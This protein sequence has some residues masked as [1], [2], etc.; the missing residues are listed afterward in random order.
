MEPT[1]TGK[2]VR[3][4]LRPLSFTQV[5][6]V[7]P[8]R[9]GAADDRIDRIY[10]EMERV[11]GVISPPVALHSPAPD[12]LA[13]SWV[14]LYETLLVPGRV[15]RAA[16]EAVATAVSVRNE[17]PYCVTVHSTMMQSLDH[18]KEAAAIAAD[19]TEEISDPEVREISAWALANALPETAAGH[20]APFPAGQAPEI[21]GT[22]LAFHYFNRVVNV[23]LPDAP[24]PPN[25]PAAMLTVVL[26]VLSRLMRSASGQT[27]P[28]GGS[29]GL[30]PNAPL[31]QNLW[32]AAGNPDV[33]QG[34]AR[35]SGAVEA[36]GLRS[37]P[38]GVREL[39]SAE[40]AAWDGQPKGPS[41][42][43][44]EKAISALPAEEQP[45][46][47]L[48]LLVALA[49]YQVDETAIDAFQAVQPTDAALVEFV[50]WAAFTASAHATTWM[51]IPGGAQ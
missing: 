50:S 19:R 8:D 33:A 45:A 16:K 20:P 23:F 28:A 10:Q 27:A 21:V 13:A 3:A 7:V 41:R 48:A 25:V 9:K 47:R 46:G 12:M 31:P 26:P 32:W 38:A 24:L 14:L 42:A 40:L 4:A 36:A 15:S 30:L 1:L 37:V 2:L 11:F 5:R 39:V 22:A 18:G 35:V 17:C 29:A 49:S 34:L 51:S 43:W 44:V 6:R